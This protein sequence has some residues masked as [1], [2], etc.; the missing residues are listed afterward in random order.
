MKKTTPITA[1]MAATPPTTPPTIA[2]MSRFL[3]DGGLILGLTP[4]TFIV[5]TGALRESHISQ[6]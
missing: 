3:R 2:P 5:S 6:E 4:L 1:K